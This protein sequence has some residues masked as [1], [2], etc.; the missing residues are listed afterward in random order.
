M[1]SHGCAVVSAMR[2]GTIQACLSLSALSADR[3]RVLF[4]LAQGIVAVAELGVPIYITETGIADA[5]GDRRGVFL[6][7][8]VPQ[9][10]PATNIN[11]NIL[12]DLI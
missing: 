2:P 8:Y 11:S 3:H 1:V 12:V 5:V 6:D 9:A 10:R 4:G 7:T